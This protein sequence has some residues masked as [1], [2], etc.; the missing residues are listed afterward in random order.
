MNS[1][2]PS[3]SSESSGSPP[4][5]EIQEEKPLSQSSG[6]L[7]H[8]RD[9]GAAGSPSKRRLP[10]GSSYGA[11]QSSRDPKTRRREREEGGTRRNAGT[12]NER[13]ASSGGAWTSQEK[14]RGPKEELAD[15]ALSELL[16]KAVGD[17]FDDSAIKSS[18]D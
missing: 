15:V 13:G 5:E 14:E 9:A 2:S 12:T 17:P 8:L 1:P 4:P 6:I 16:K 11:S 7:G 3:P 10:G 18:A